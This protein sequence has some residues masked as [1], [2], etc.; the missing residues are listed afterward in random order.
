MLKALVKGYAFGATIRIAYGDTESGDKDPRDGVRSAVNSGGY[1][2][3]K[4]TP[5]NKIFALRVLQHPMT[6][7]MPV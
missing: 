4:T 3:A 7:A 2:A 1:C 5:P 6:P